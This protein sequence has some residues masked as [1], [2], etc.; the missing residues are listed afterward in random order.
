VRKLSDWAINSADP[1][2]TQ[3]VLQEL[4]G[5]LASAGTSDDKRQRYFEAIDFAELRLS[6]CFASSFAG[7]GWI[8]LIHTPRYW[9]IQ[10]TFRATEQ[11]HHQLN[12]ELSAQHR[13]VESAIHSLQAVTEQMASGYPNAVGLVLDT[14]IHLHFKPFWELPWNDLVDCREVRLIVPTVVIWELDN[15]KNAGGKRG[16]R[17]SL[18]LKKLRELLHD[19]RGPVE[20]G[21]GVSVEVPFGFDLLDVS[22]ADEAILATATG[23]SGRF[24]KGSVLSPATTRCSY[25]RGL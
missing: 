22:N 13:Q 12:A 3:E 8:D 25:K 15:K 9:E 20:V 17:A 14:N 10:R 19:G 4:K 1:Q 23:L 7:G 24:K 5:L 16:D 21:T 2:K 18:R 6:E 11:P